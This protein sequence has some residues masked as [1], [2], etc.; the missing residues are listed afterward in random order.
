MTVF[1]IIVN[2]FCRVKNK[3]KFYYYIFQRYDR[4]ETER[5]EG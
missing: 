4:R 5:K 3:F 2:V 1:Y